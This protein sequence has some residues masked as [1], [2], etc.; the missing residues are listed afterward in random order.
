M[1][2]NKY[3]FIR[4]NFDYADEFYVESIHVMK[5]SAWEKLKED[6]ETYFSK[7][8][9][10]EIECYFGT[11]EQIIFEK[12]N[13]LIRGVFV[14]PITDEERKTLADLLGEDELSFSW[15]TGSGI[16]ENLQEAIN[17]RN[18]EDKEDEE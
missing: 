5:A 16:F 13:D 3:V 12:Y 10:R 1:S 15:G 9:A 18:A 2:K 11:N 17:D 14:K 8:S 7:K 4:A 6:V